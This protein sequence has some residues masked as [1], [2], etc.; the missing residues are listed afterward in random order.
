MYSRV[1]VRVRTDGRDIYDIEE[2]RRV[3]CTMSLD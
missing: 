1:L 2:F 3:F